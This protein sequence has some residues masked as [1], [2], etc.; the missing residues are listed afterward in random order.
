MD[1]AGNPRV[2]QYGSLNPLKRVKFIS[3]EFVISYY[4]LLKES[5][6]PQT[7][8]VYFNCLLGG[9]YAGNF[10]RLNPL[11]RVKFISI[12]EEASQIIREAG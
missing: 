11:K 10:P 5:Q 7:G 3:M 6:S 4:E 12:R 1:A 8:Q 2:S 9:G